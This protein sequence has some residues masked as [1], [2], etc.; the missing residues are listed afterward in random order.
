MDFL[1]VGD[2][3]T[4]CEFKIGVLPE[5]VNFL[6]DPLNKCISFRDCGT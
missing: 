1:L 4:P 2:G 3:V 5:S 6:A